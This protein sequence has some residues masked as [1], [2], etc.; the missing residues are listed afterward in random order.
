MK[1]NTN[2]KALY[3]FVSIGEGVTWA[4]LLSSLLVRA[5]GF[6]PSW[7]VTAAGSIHGFMFLSYAVMAALVGVNQRWRILRIL[8]AVALAIV[9][10]ATVPF[11]KAMA[12]KGAL[13]G[14]WRLTKTEDPRDANWF[15]SLFRWFINRP[16]V[17]VLVLLLAVSLVFAL[18]LS[19]G[20]PDQWF[21]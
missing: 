7:L 10:F 15:D 12:K 17:L 2:P 6:A 21:K 3:G 13:E 20:P 1:I 5:A 18:L 9:P 16:L 11:D 8:S 19:A 4:I 14:A